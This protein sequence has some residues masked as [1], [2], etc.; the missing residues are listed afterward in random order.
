V[1]Y[2][3]LVAFNNDDVPVADLTFLLPRPEA[4]VVAA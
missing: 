4:A 1:H 2:S 3:L